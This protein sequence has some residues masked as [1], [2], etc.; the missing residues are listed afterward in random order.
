M[1]PQT[2]HSARFFGC[3]PPKK[4]KAECSLRD[5]PMN[6]TVQSEAIYWRAEERPKRML[7]F[8][9]FRLTCLDTSE[10]SSRTYIVVII[11]SC[12]YVRCLRIGS[13]LIHSLPTLNTGV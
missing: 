3:H 5:R 2:E 13:P 1:N 10:N 9:G 7:Q 8:S 11:R 6:V 4:H 12:S